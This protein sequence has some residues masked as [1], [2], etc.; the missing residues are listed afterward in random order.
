MIV[1]GMEIDKAIEE[2]VVK[3]MMSRRFYC[4][5]LATLGQL[6]GLTPEIAGRLADRLT[7]RASRRGEIRGTGLAHG[8][9]EP[10]P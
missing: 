7:Q 10:V 1:Q 3:R 4:R 9:W 8:Q 2:A 6:R 5:E